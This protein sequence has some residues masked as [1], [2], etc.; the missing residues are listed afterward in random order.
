MV[1]ATPPAKISTKK[2]VDLWASLPPNYSEADLGANLV[3]RIFDYLGLNHHQIKNNLNIGRGLQPD[4][5]IYN[6]PGQPPVLV[7]ET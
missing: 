3:A 1:T 5:L 7:I 6:D 4:Y 2:I